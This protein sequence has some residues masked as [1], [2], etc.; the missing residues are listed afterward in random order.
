[1][2]GDMEVAMAAGCA[3]YISKPIDT[4]SFGEQMRKFLSPVTAEQTLGPIA[5]PRPS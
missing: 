2:I 1:M 4:R 3:G 5:D